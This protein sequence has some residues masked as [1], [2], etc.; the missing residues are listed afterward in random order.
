MDYFSKLLGDFVSRHQFDQSDLDL[1][2]DFTCSEE[3][4]DGFCKQ[5]T[6]LEFKDAFFTLPRNKAS[7]P[8]DYTFEVF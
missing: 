3:E 2:F 5:F 7:G 4:S 8:D 6:P 1:L